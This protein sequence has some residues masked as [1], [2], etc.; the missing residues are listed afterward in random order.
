MAIVRAPEKWIGHYVDI[1]GTAMKDGD[2]WY[3]IAR[4]VKDVER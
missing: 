1:N 4:A 3:N 2:V